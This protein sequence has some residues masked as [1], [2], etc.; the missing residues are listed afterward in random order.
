MGIY[1]NPRNIVFYRLVNSELYVD[2]SLL[3]EYINRI[4][5]TDR[6]ML[7]VSR[8]RRFG[9]SMDANMLVAY[10]SKG[11]DSSA[12]FDTLNISKADDYKDHLNQHNVILLNMQTFLSNT[13]NIDTMIELITKRI[14]NEVKRCYDIDLFDETKLSMSLEDVYNETNQSF[15]FIID[16]WD[17]IFREFKTEKRKQEAYLD[18][19]RDLLKDKPYVELAYMTGILPIKKY[20]THSALNMFEEI[21]MITPKKL[22][23]FMGF[24][25]KEVTELCQ[26]FDM[27]FNDIRNWYDG[28]RLKDI[29]IYSPRSVNA[30]LSNHEILNYWNDTETFEA[31]RIYIDRNY[32][33]LKESIIEMLSG[34]KVKI[35]VTSF[36]NDMTTFESKDDIMTLLIHL[37]YLGYDSIN[38]SVYIPNKEV[39]SSFITSIKNSHWQS[40]KGLVDSDE[41]LKAIWQKQEKKVAEYL[42]KAHLNTSILEYNSE[43]ALK[44]TVLLACYT[45]GDYYQT[46]L[47]MPSGEGY[48][49]I[50][51]LPKE[52]KPAMIIELKWNKKADGA[53]K[54]IKT[55]KYLEGFK[56]YQGE[57]M[58]V[59]ISYDKNTKKHECQIEVVNQ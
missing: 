55:R 47:E 25:E 32:D 24:T 16:E 29:S 45:A 12:I 39:R 6:N 33:G 18:F 36:Q 8:P 17:C 15:I 37:G 14:I 7:C 22:S 10:Y 19:L 59:G 21:S 35:D 49:D 53:I 28:Y 58:L 23:H 42:E 51:Y 52:D 38:K 50:A 44:Y 46:I 20:G 2:H 4:I 11:C 26:Q 30:S 13:H 34:E 56:D 1:L 43:A 40:A 57:V 27:D 3:I 9:K 31:L 41:L 54:Q 5:D 48:I